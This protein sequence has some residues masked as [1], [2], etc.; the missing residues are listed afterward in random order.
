MS[1][2][3]LYSRLPNCCDNAVICFLFSSAMMGARTIAQPSGPCK[4]CVGQAV[5][6]QKQN[7]RR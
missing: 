5:S 2:S 1:L 4:R 3:N 7:K 6:G